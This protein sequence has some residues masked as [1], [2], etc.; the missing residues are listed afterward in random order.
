MNGCRGALEET[1][2]VIW[3]RNE[4]KRKN[5]ILFSTLCNVPDDSL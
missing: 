5:M 1:E 2:K 3:E 4:E